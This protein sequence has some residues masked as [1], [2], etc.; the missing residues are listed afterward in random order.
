MEG[1]PNLQFTIT[2]GLGIHVKITNK[3]TINSSDVVWEI[4]VQGGIFGLIN[5]TINGTVD[6]AKGETK[7]VGTGMFLGFGGIQITATVDEGT[8]TVSGI[9]LFIFIMVKK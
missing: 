7:T 6:V 1:T 2:G 3:G 4:H 5:S 8:K 9:Q